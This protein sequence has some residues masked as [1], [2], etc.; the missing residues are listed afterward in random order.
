MCFSGCS[1]WNLRCRKNG[2]PYHCRHVRPVPYPPGPLLTSIADFTEQPLVEEEF[3]CLATA[4][5]V[6]ANYDL[7]VRDFAP[8]FGPSGSVPD[9]GT[10]AAIDEFL[11]DHCGVISDRQ[12]AQCE[13][14]APVELRGRKR[15]GYRPPQYGRAAVFPVD[16]QPRLIDVKGIGVQPH[17]T[18]RRVKHYTGLLAASSAIRELL[19]EWLTAFALEHGGAATAVVPTYALLDL[20]F[21]AI[22]PDG[23][24]ERAFA[25]ARRAHTRPR[26]SWGN[27]DPSPEMVVA[28]REI[29][30]LL[31]RYGLIPVVTEFQVR[32][33]GDT[34]ILTAFGKEFVFEGSE[35]ERV[36][37]LT[38]CNE[39]DVTL[40][41][42]DLQFVSG[43]NGTPQIVDFGVF[44]AR[45]KFPHPIF[46]C[47]SSRNVDLVG[48]IV[49][50]DDVDS[51]SRAAVPHEWSKLG[52]WLAERYRRHGRDGASVARQLDTVITNWLAEL[53]R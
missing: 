14:N 36:A 33:R 53:D 48:E 46:I 51:T 8:R 10:R 23:T 21:D 40:E 19:F 20:G 22:G 5:I 26:K 31:H 34:V 17:A 37:A 4:R 30:F 12:A 52:I 38:G 44:R 9:A 35:A 13:T 24:R 2:L 18:P 25:I 6:L 7:V 27:E 42:V 15:R 47:T 1:S 29:V 43:M 11:I 39:Q 41:S 3:H 45:A 16:D 49:R 32:R 50:L 28:T